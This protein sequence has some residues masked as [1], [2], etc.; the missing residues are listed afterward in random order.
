ME[1]A[2][3]LTPLW[4][5]LG[6]QFEGWRKRRAVAKPPAHQ[7]EFGRWV[8]TSGTST[9]LGRSAEVTLQYR[10]CSTCGWKDVRNL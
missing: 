7:H 5:F 8:T 3:L 10:V 4:F 2:F 6:W 1:I 9:F